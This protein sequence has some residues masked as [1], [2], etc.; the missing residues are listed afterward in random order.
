VADAPRVDRGESGPPTRPRPAAIRPGPIEG[1]GDRVPL[2]FAC[3]QIVPRNIEVGYGPGVDPGTPVSWKGGETWRLVLG[4]AIAPLGL[5]M[6]AA[7][8]RLTIEQ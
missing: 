2:S 4:R 7:G 3:R 8:M 1:F 6:V 5:R